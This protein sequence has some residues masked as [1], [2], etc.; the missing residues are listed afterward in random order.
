MPTR[1]LSQGVRVQVRNRH[2]TESTSYTD[3]CFASL[4]EIF[5]LV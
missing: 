1:A 4:P 5:F 3:E 2:V